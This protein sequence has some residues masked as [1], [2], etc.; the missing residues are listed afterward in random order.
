MAEPKEK[1]KAEPPPKQAEMEIPFWREKVII[2]VLVGIFAADQISKA[3]VV[4]RFEKPNDSSERLIVIK[5]FL[6]LIHRTNDGAAFSILQGKNNILAVISFI[7]MGGLICF[8]HH[9]DNGTRVSK[10]ALG[11][12]MGGVLGNLTDRVFRESV[13]DFVRVYVE[14]RGGVVSE[15]PA[16]NVA[17]AAICTGVGFLFYIAWT[18]GGEEEET[19]Q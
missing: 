10:L 16:F 2:L 13:V 14:R 15:W 9:F 19:T 17:D 12:L 3:L 5:G 7:A 18:E 4:Q 11:L 1:G 6:D 8:R